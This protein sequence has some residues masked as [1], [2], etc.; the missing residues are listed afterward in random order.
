MIM[1]LNLKR[2]FL[3]TTLLTSMLVMS[4]LTA[5]GQRKPAESASNDSMQSAGVEAYPGT[6]EETNVTLLPLITSTALN[7]PYP[8]RSTDTAGHTQEKPAITLTPPPPRIDVGA[9]YGTLVSWSN[10]LPLPEVNLFAAEKVYIGN[11]RDYVIA[12]QEKSSPQGETNAIGQFVIQAIP[13]G[14]YLLMLITPGGSYSGFDKNNK[15]I[16]LKIEPN[17]VIDLGVVSIN[18]P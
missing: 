11:T 8:V 7:N 14:E 4:V 10:E 2:L 13:P 1:I 18:W 16:D 5:C 9:V 6:I 3:L 17:S 15:E 12:I